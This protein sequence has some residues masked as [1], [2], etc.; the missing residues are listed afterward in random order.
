ME[1]EVE[2]LWRAR[3]RWRWRGALMW[4]AFV[5]LTVSD[6][7]LLGV[8][9]IAGDGG[10]S[11]VGALLLAMFFN[12]LAVAVVGPLTALLLRRRRPD[13]PKVVAEDYAGT[14]A[15]LAVTAALLAGGLAHAPARE[16]AERDHADQ[17]RAA[18]AYAQTSAPAQYRRHAG[19]LNTLKLEDGLFRTCLPGDDPQR[20]FCMYVS[21]RTSPPGVTVDPNR[22]S[23]AMLRRAGGFR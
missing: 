22:E 5:V 23:N 6:A 15:L 19:A 18:A 14:G 10:T 20:W 3:M 7:L 16:R 8:L 17:L 13:L 11:L 9:P 2:P 12:L 1:R 4:P 21:T